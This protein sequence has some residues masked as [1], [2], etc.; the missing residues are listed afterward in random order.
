[1]LEYTDREQG[2][3][4]GVPPIDEKS[5]MGSATLEHQLYESLTSQF[6][7]NAQRQKFGSGLDIERLG[8]FAGFDYR[9]KNPFGV[10]LANYRFFAQEEKRSGG[11]QTFEILDERRTFND[12]EPIVLSNTNIAVASLFVTAEDR[13]TLFREGEDYR[14]RVVGDQVEIERVPTGRI[15]DG[16]T[17][18]I[19]YRYD[20]GGDF[21]LNTRSQHFGLRENF[22]FG[23]SPYYRLRWQDQTLSP[24]DATGVTPD[25]IT[26]HL[27]GAEYSKGPLRMTAE[28]EHYDSTV[29]PFEAT[30]L[31]ADLRHR[32]AS[33]LTGSIQGRWSDIER[34]L[35][36]LRETKFFTL[37]GRV[38]HPITPKF[39]VEAAALYRRE[40]DSLNGNDEGVDF[41]FTLEWFLRQTEVRVKYKFGK[42]DDNFAQN[43]TSSLFVQVKRKF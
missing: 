33:G 42:F 24:E 35:V 34:M 31:S 43:D 11:Q 18:M 23:L 17:V 26:A 9:K 5:T 19:D 13:T 40:R 1:V 12:P 30:R 16:Q 3:L 4:S 15:A 10:L 7:L 29:N 8:G 41:D 37:E 36:P 25:D 28:F 27:Y 32:F 14:L 39:S 6:Q 2:T 38:R 22:A 20:V 21:T